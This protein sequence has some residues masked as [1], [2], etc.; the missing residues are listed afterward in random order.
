MWS[1]VSVVVSNLFMEDYE[2][3]AITI[4]PPEMKPKIWKRYI[5][6]SFE[7]IKK[8]Q[9]DPF[10]DYLNSIDPTGSIKF[11]DESEVEKTISFLDAQITRKE[12]GTLKVNVYRKKTH[13]DQYLNFKSHH[14]LP[15][16]LGVVKIPYE[17][18]DN[19]IMVPEDQKQQLI[20]FNNTLRVCGYTK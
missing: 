18:D 8:D 17:R 7:I 13:T 10:T 14:S 15:H 20:N 19:I 3:M 1:P 5:D 9:R 4:A 6:D 12:D 16:K 11:T 2:E